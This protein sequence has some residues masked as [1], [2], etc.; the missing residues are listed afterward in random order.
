[1]TVLI[2]IV[3]TLVLI[4]IIPVLDDI[5]S[6]FLYLILVSVI[7]GNM[8]LFFTDIPTSTVTGFYVIYGLMVLV[9]A[10]RTVYVYGKVK[11]KLKFIWGD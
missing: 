6:T 7:A 8:A 1:M 10:H 9:A 5:Y 3:V 4:L 11:G 2:P